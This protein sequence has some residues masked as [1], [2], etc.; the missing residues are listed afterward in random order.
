MNTRKLAEV[1]DLPGLD[2]LETSELLAL[3]HQGNRAAYATL[4]DRYAYPAHR[5]A[6]HLGMRDEAEDVVAESFARI[7]DLMRRG[8][9]P[10]SNFRSYLFTTVRHEAGHRAKARQKVVPTDDE[11]QIDSPVPFGGNQLDQFE[12]STIRAAYESLPPRWQS[13]LWQLDVEGH[14]PHELAEALHVSP[15]SVSAL[16]YRAR[17]GLREAY[18]QQHVAGAD[19]GASQACVDARS[20]LPLA[21]AALSGF[22]S[23]RKDSCSSGTLR[24]MHGGLH[25]PAGDRFRDRAP[26]PGVATLI[27]ARPSLTVSDT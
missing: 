3:V 6:R 11:S 27:R 13:V 12:R 15:N 10:A 14:K 26:C 22:P 20:Q 5:L 24:G 17:A 25:G 23:S 21:R 9:G 1:A 16:A 2:D 4:Y 8:K 18:L 7:L 19:P